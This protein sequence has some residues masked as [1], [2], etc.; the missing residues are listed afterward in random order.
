[1]AQL[2]PILLTPK[3]L[4]T[5]RSWRLYFRTPL[6]TQCVHWSQTL[7]KS[8]PE[9]FCTIVSFLCIKLRRKTSLLVRPKILGL[10]VNTLT[11]HDKFSC[12]KNENFP[13]AIQMQSSK[14]PKIFY[15][16]LIEILE[17]SLNFQHFEKKDEPQSSINSEIIDSERP[18]YLNA[19]KAP[20]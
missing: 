19:W 9:Q 20:F 6:W 14:Q 7:V 16:L 8:E 11:S 3:Y 1:M 13:Q 5:Y 2:Y 12:Y 10:F 4:V 15:E 18:G 17:S